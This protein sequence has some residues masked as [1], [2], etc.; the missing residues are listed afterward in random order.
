MILGR[1]ANLYLGLASAA[2]ALVW[3]VA[4]A[5]DTPFPPELAAVVLTFIGAVIA[6]LAGND[7][8]A[9]R[10]GDAAARRLAVRRRS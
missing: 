6:L 9:V 8:L 7:T 2:I 10:K 3:G 5:V 4:A 1:S